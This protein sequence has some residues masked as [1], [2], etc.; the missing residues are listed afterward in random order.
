M[1]SEIRSFQVTIPAGTP[2]SAPFTQAIAFPPRTVVQVDW[3]VPPGPSGLMGWALTVAGQPVIPRNPGSYI[4]ADGV[5]R[6]WPL[7]GYPD[8]GAWQVT[9]YNTDIYP[10]TVYLDLLLEQNG[11]QTAQPVQIANSDLSSPPPPAA[12]PV[13]PVP[14]L[15]VA[16][17]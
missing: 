14:D 5:Q 12:P 7:E 3:Q 15:T 9:G 16:G 10:H 6:S 1:A 2:V 8:Q 17:V 4:V 11:T 13:V